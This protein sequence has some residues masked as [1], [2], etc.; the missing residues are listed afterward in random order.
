MTLR[1]R[2][3][4]DSAAL[5]YTVIFIRDGAGA[6]ARLLMIERLFEPN[7]GKRNGVGGKIDPGES[8]Y[9]CALREVRE[10]TGIALTVASFAGVVTW[11][12]DTASFHKSGARG[13]YVYLADLPAG[14]AP[15]S[16]ARETPEGRLTWCPLQDVLS[17]SDAYANNVPDFLRPIIAGAA[18]AEYYCDYRDVGQRYL[19]ITVHPLPAEFAELSGASAARGEVA[20]T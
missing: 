6:D 5:P 16:V 18:P 7:R 2:T 3:G 20:G 10:E 19:G 9:Q 14:L 17:G 12:T 11:T 1:T 4:I 15:D 8:P 13:M